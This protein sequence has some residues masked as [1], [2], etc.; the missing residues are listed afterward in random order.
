MQVLKPKLNATKYHT[1][2]SDIQY[3]EQSRSKELYVVHGLNELSNLDS[4]MQVKHSFVEPNFGAIHSIDLSNSMCTLVF[5]RDAKQLVRLNRDLTVRN[6]Y[7]LASWSSSYFD[8]LALANDQQVWVYNVQQHRLEKYDFNGV[9]QTHSFN[10]TDRLNPRLSIL[11]LTVNKDYVYAWSADNLVYCFD[12]LGQYIETVEARKL[13]KLPFIF[14]TTAIGQNLDAAVKSTCF[15][16]GE[17]LYYD[18]YGIL[19]KDSIQR[20]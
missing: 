13:D 4:N 17:C 18:T 11:A 10:L 9:L 8:A 5:Y 3:M 2:L 12:Y 7:D 15:S 1:L 14:A 6:Q 19:K 20:N 16:N